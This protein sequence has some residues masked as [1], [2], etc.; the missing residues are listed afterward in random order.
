MKSVKEIFDFAPCCSPGRQQVVWGESDIGRMLDIINPLYS[1][2]HG[3]LDESWDGGHSST[4]KDFIADPCTRQLLFN[5]FSYPRFGKARRY[6]SCC[7]MSCF[8][9]IGPDD[10]ES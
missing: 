7:Y 10:K 9:W 3:G 8:R 5:A 2:W 4:A 1:S 6:C